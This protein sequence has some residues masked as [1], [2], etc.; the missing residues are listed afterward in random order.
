MSL[1]T[2]P[3]SAAS[4]GRVSVCVACWRARLGV[5]VRVVARENNA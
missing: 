4:C 2:M 5:P 3:A 1:L